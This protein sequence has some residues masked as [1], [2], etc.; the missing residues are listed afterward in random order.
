MDWINGIRGLRL[1]TAASLLPGEDGCQPFYDRIACENGGMILVKTPDGDGPI[2][3]GGKQL[4]FK[5]NHAVGVAAGHDIIT[6]A[7]AE[8]QV[9]GQLRGP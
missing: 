5:G 4:A 9:V 1:L 6:A 3:G 8:K 7:M 2:L